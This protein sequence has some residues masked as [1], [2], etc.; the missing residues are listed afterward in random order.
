MKNV[1]WKGRRRRSNKGRGGAKRA[2]K[3]RGSGG[4]KS[5]FLLEREESQVRMSYEWSQPQKKISSDW[6]KRWNI[7]EECGVGM[8]RITWSSELFDFTMIVTRL[9]LLVVLCNIDWAFQTNLTMLQPLV[10]SAKDQNWWNPREIS[11]NPW[12]LNPSWKSLPNLSGIGLET[13]S[14][15]LFKVTHVKKPPKR[16]VF[17]DFRWIK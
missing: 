14:G 2:R 5:I 15:E 11:Q 12:N 17:Y 3:S 1:E 6:T 13:N 9:S 10:A 7:E 8:M 16:D 4:G